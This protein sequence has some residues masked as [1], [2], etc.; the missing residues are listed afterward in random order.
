MAEQNG[1]EKSNVEFQ[2]GKN[3]NRKDYEKTIDY[4][5]SVEILRDF[6][7][8]VLDENIKKLKDFDFT[9][10]TTYVGDIIDPDMYL[11]TQ[12]IYIILWGDLYD[13]TF[14]KMGS[15][16]W[17]NEY[18]FRGDTM[19]S[20]GSLFGKE[21]KKKDRSFAFRAK[22]YNADQNPRLW[23]KINKFSKSYHHIGNFIVI[24]NR[25]TLR[26]GINGARAG[27][28]NREEC[29]GMR[30]YFDWFL[31]AVTN[32]QNKV[33]KGDIHLS[34]FEMQLQMNPEYNPAFLSI[35]DWEERF[36]LRPYFEDGEPVALF[37]TPLEERL[38]VTDPNGA[39]RIY[40][41]Y[42]R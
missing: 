19:N 35:K 10:L 4:K 14:E 23:K 36:Y 7:R 25:G 37:K 38:K 29:E 26:N 31:I 27:Y 33:K 18:A 40:S 20:F 34:R 32:Y 11:I 13:L 42:D 8:D 22:L 9:D 3:M 5:K 6:T 21:D 24:P 30:D 41:G 15:W 2:K 28:Y 12:A 17:S 39:K 16:N 1:V